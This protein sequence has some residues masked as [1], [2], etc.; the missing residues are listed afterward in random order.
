MT[1]KYTCGA[2]RLPCWAK[3]IDVPTTLPGPVPGPSSDSTKTKH[4]SAGAISPANDRHERSMMPASASRSS[5]R[6]TESRCAAA[7]CRSGRSAGETSRSRNMVA[8]YIV[9]LAR[10]PERVP[11]LPRWA[12]TSKL[13]SAPTL[14]LVPELGQ[15]PPHIGRDVPGQRPQHLLEAAL[16]H[17][18]ARQQH[19][20]VDDGHRWPSLLDVTPVLARQ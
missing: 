18:P 8:N 6:F 4:R 13:V 11:N 7:S 1:S 20:V 9:Y 5:G 17:R 10:N 16:G 15:P 2:R 14:A 12:A 19:V 3:I